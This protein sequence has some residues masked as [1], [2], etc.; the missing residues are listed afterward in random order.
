MVQSKYCHYSIS[1]RARADNN[2]LGEL[3]KYMIQHGPRKTLATSRRVRVIHNHIYIVDTTRTTL[4][5]EHNYFPHFYIPR[6]EIQHCVLKDKHEVQYDGTIGAAV[7]ELLVPAHDGLDE[8]KTDRVIRFADDERLGAIAG[9][10]RLEFG[11]MGKLASV[12]YR[13]TA[14]GT[15]RSMA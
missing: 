2:S 5:W 10:V 9:M 4:V 14:N 3:A 6:E 7:V 15:R 13:D 12:R 8:V 11:S 1:M